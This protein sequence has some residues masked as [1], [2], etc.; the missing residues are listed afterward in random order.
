MLEVLDS[1]RGVQFFGGETTFINMS[2]AEKNII[3]LEHGKVGDR[4]AVVLNGQQI[5]KK[6][7]KPTQ[8][9]RFHSFVFTGMVPRKGTGPRAAW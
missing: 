3:G 4:I 2:R 7:Y 5:Y 9:L 6:L 1:R 8:T